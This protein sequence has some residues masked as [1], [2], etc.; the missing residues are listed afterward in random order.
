MFFA[1]A[2]MMKTKACEAIVKILE[3]EGVTAAFGI[4]GAGING[5]YKYL[6]QSKQ[7]KHYCHRHE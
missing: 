5:V 7:I 4:P 2:T 3:I 6:G 1:A